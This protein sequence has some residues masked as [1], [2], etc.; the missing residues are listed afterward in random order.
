MGLVM[1]VRLPSHRRTRRLPRRRTRRPGGRRR[2][3][4]PT[5]T[6]TWQEAG[7]RRVPPGQM[8]QRPAGRPRAGAAAA[9]TPGGSAA[10]HRADLHRSV[11]RHTAHT[12][13]LH[14]PL[15]TGHASTPSPTMKHHWELNL[16]LRR[17]TLHNDLNFK[18]QLTPSCHR[19]PPHLVC[20]PP[21]YRLRVRAAP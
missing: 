16:K 6:C 17:F 18:L 5:C 8:A 3:A 9:R 15:R 20:A 7:A 10:A 14:S 21:V 1:H 13:G 2:A 19:R 12:T 4:R 11:L